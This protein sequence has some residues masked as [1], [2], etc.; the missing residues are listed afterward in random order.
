MHVSI[1]AIMIHDPTLADVT[2]RRRASTALQNRLIGAVLLGERR[3]HSWWHGPDDQKIL[4]FSVSAVLPGSTETQFF[5]QLADRTE[6]ERRGKS[7]G[8]PCGIRLLILGRELHRD[9][10]TTRQNRGR[11]LGKGC[12]IQFHAR[13]VCS[14]CPET[15]E[16][17]MST[18]VDFS[19]SL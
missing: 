7:F 5:K 16:D 17:N 14:Q 19:E 11:Y 10:M 3:K 9:T 15:D 12:V 4:V 18:E 13:Y 8:Y 1:S 2:D 6:M